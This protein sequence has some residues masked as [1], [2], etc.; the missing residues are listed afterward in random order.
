MS[1]L[2]GYYST[3]EAANILGYKDISSIS[4]LCSSGKV[5]GAKNIGKMWFIPESWV[6]AV[7][8]DPVNP[9]GNR[10]I[11]RKERKS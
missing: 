5:P 9:K 3:R 1:D 10:G 7:K 2:P 4:R 11:K 6:E 8:K